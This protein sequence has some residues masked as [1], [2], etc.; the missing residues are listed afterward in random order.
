MISTVLRLILQDLSKVSARTI[1]QHSLAFYA[2]CRERF[3]SGTYGT[4]VDWVIRGGLLSTGPREQGL[5]TYVL[6]TVRDTKGE[7]PD[8]NPV[9]IERK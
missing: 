6:D 2:V 9:Q 3:L 8:A 1:L 7:K 4:C 5:M